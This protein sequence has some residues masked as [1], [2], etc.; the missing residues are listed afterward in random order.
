MAASAPA[1]PFCEICQTT[2]IYHDSDEVV[3]CQSCG[4]PWAAPPPPPPPSLVESIRAGTIAELTALAAPAAEAFWKRYVLEKEVRG[5]LRM[6][7]RTFVE[8]R[9]KLE[10]G[11]V[12]LTP[13]EG[14]KEVFMTIEDAKR[15]IADV[16]SVE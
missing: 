13:P 15:L 7:L 12:R 14:Q 1:T 16:V 2:I 9:L 6:G 10:I 5:I 4:R 11:V 3:T 8:W